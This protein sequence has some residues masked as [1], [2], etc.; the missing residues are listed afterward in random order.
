MSNEEANKKIH[1]SLDLFTLTAPRV[2]KNVDG[3]KVVKY[4]TAVI[5]MLREDTDSFGHRNN[6]SFNLDVIL[7]CEY[8]TH[9][10]LQRVTE[11]LLLLPE[12]LNSR[13]NNTEK[14]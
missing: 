14:E 4:T 6:F 13:G 1:N 11:L 7:Y 5:R 10:Y 8:N 9:T 3:I 12:F 2:Y